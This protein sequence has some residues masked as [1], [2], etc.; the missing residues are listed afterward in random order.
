MLYTALTGGGLVVFAAFLSLYSYYKNKSVTMP[1]VF[2]AIATVGL[3][4]MLV[5]GGLWVRPYLIAYLPNA[6][7][8]IL[9]GIIVVAIL[10]AFWF[11]LR[12][13]FSQHKEKEEEVK[14]I[15]ATG[16]KTY[17]VGGSGATSTGKKK[18]KKNN[19]MKAQMGTSKK[20]RLPRY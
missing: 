14:R 5:G 6:T 11:L 2:A 9:I 12:P 15:T 13:A 20:R 3:V 16:T 18:K 1:K 4:V 8:F 19:S 17:T 10:L 7:D